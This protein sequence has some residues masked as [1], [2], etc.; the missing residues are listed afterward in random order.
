[1]TDKTHV[2]GNQEPKN[3]KD[4]LLRQAGDDKLVKAVL[5]G[6][7]GVIFPGIER[8][9][10]CELEKP[11]EKDQPVV[12]PYGRGVI[13]R[14]SNDLCEA[15]ADDGSVNCF[16]IPRDTRE[17]EWFGYGKGAI[18]IREIKD[19]GRCFSAYPEDGSGPVE[20]CRFQK[21]IEW[22]GYEDGAVIHDTVLN[23]FHFHSGKATP[24]T[25]CA[26]KT[27]DNWR[28]YSNGVITLEGKNNFMAYTIN[29]GSTPKQMTLPVPCEGWRT[30]R[31]GVIFKNIDKFTAF[32]IPRGMIDICKPA[33]DEWIAYGNGIIIREG[34][35][36]IAYKI[37]NEQE[38]LSKAFEDGMR[39]KL[40]K[41]TQEAGLKMGLKGGLGIELGVESAYK[42]KS[43]PSGLEGYIGVNIDF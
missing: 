33:F 34:N 26:K 31:N 36:F 11:S 12:R 13:V 17:E 28:G 41:G 30:Y 8:I 6:R 29:K 16:I 35:K 9:V 27:P 14:H 10:L 15:F 24:Y 39:E 40:F 2:L 5:E 3:L 18:R 37:V 19:K 23:E 22:D 43:E 42:D 38:Q 20:L 25:I 32:P 21:S 7:D 4:R 1:M